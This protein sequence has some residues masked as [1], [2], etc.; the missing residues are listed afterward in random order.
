MLRL[1]V[2]ATTATVAGLLVLPPATA[3]AT[4]T[5]FG[6]KATIVGTKK[7]DRLAGTPARDVIV[8]LG[9]EDTI[10]GG[11]G[12]DLICGGSGADSLYGGAG[13]D[14]VNGGMGTLDIDRGG[15][16]V[17]NDTIVP[18]AGNDIVV[19]VF[20]NRAHS[21]E[22]DR[23]D[24]SDSPRGLRVDI[25]R[26][27]VNG[28]GFDR[29]ASTAVK[30]VGSRYADVMRGGSGADEF[31][32]HGGADELLGGPGNDYLR[33]QNYGPL[34]PDDTTADRLAGGPGNDLI[35]GQGG[36]DTLTGGS[37]NDQVDDEGQ[38]ADTIDLGP[39]NDASVD[40]W[41]WRRG[42]SITGGSGRDSFQPVLRFWRDGKL[43]RPHTTVD[44]R[45]G[46]TTMDL[47]AEQQIRLSGIEAL[48]FWEGGDLTFH[49]TDADEEVGAFDRARLV[50]HAYG[51]DDVLRGGFRNDVLDGGE[52]NDTAVPEVGRDRC[53][54]IEHQPEGRCE[55][56]E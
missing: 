50:A 51:G 11:Q 24:F 7:A 5:C 37:G 6:E 31:V 3:Q 53:I 4:P 20:D 33:D 17:V 35:I 29:L 44:L 9:G 41:N 23:V 15:Q 19:P 46:I 34:D 47:Q 48:P 21:Y 39:G 13:N 25:A 18:G 10:R 55:V 27:T 26:K 2:L 32:G 54:S 12:N 38:S 28:H 36:P 56:N 49:G 42:T 52:G 40:V 14:R 22:R 1:A 45:S 16:F 43:L 30:I 8:G